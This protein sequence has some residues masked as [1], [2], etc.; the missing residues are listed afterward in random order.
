MRYPIRGQRFVNEGLGN[1][2]TKRNSDD[3]VG[4]FAGLLQGR[5][6]VMSRLRWSQ[7]RWKVWRDSLPALIVG[8]DLL[9]WCHREPFVPTWENIGEWICHCDPLYVWAQRWE[10]THPAEAAV[11]RR[12]L[13][14]TA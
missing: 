2:F 3:P 8:H 5:Y 6:D 1:P 4:D 10:Q 14:T 9:C 12:E 11:L 13:A 7:A